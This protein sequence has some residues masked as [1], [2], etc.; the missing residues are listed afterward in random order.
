MIQE[1]VL[2][3]EQ[4]KLEQEEANVKAMVDK[5]EDKETKWNGEAPSDAEERNPRDSDL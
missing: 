2:K 1:R 3:K 5:F 4:A